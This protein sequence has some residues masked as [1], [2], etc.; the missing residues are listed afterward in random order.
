MDSI[1]LEKTGVKCTDRRHTRVAISELASSDPQHLISGETD[2]AIL[3][4][5]FGVSLG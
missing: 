3:S 1:Q 4:H 5:H 2:R